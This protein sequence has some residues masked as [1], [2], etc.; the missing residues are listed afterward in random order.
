MSAEKFTDGSKPK[1]NRVE[2][3]WHTVT[4]RTIVLYV[5]AFVILFAAAGYLVFPDTFT[6]IARRLSQA[7]EPKSSIVASTDV[8]GARFVNLDGKVQVKKVN[9]VQWTRADYQMTLDR[10][11]L[12]QTGPDGVAR[13]AFADGTKYTVQADTLVTVEEIFVPANRASSVSM[14]ISSGAV[15]LTTG[16]W[17]IPGSKAEVS[18]QDAVASLHE[19]SRADVKT[20]PTTKQNEITVAAGAAEV[21]RD[22]QQVQVA[23]WQRAS[24]TAGGPITKTD[25]LAPPGLIQP[26]NLQP[27][28]VADPKTTPVRFEWQPVSTAREYELE[29][30]DSSMFTRILADRKTTDTAVEVTGLDAGDYFWTVKAIDAKGASSEPGGPSK[31]TLIEQGKEQSMLLTVDRVEFDG[32]VVEIIG[33]TEPGAALIIDGEPVADIGPDGRFRHFTQPMTSGAHE[34][35]ITG[36]DRRG[37]A[38]IKRVPVVVP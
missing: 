17:Q 37:G 38:T 22:G 1:V 7:L 15:D 11:D 12:I 21:K 31:F 25:V 30:S 36:Q 33:H 9:S 16:T 32:K 2:V 10:G 18:F 26:V 14:H 13:I 35:V 8:R 5:L 19:N 6:G 29:I 4:Y 23:Q 24:F 20:D 34:I 3:Y 27:I 28:I